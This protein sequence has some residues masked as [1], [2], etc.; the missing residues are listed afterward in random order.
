MLELSGAAIA[1]YASM[2]TAQAPLR[3]AS[4]AGGRFDR[5]FHTCAFVRSREEEYEV[6][7][8]FVSEAFAW[9]EKALYIV[10]PKLAAEHPERLALGGVLPPKPSQLAVLTWE[11]TYLRNGAFDKDMMLET[12]TTAIGAG[13]AEGFARSRIIGQMGWALEDKPGSDQLLEYEVQ[14]NEVLAR[15]RNPAVCVYDLNKLSGSMMMDLMRV[16][17]MSIVGGV[18]YE[19]PFYVASDKMLAELRSRKRMH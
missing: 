17:P 3:A 6:V 5:F 8:P 11:E 9:G 1:Q 12:V 15:T 10:D 7:G 14:V 19:N 18:L 16:H 4:I 2:M 13:E